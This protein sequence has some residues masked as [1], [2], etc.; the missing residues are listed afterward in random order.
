MLRKIAWTFVAL[1][2]AAT[3]VFALG[4]RTPVDTTITFDPATIGSDLDAYLAAEEAKVPGIRDGLQKEIIWAFPQSKAKT[5]YA[6]VYV[7]GFSASKGEVRPLPDMVASALG[8]NLF[9]TRLTGHGQGGEAMASAS[10]NA[11]VNDFAEAL[12]IGRTIGEKVILIS[13]STG[14]GLV[15]LGA[16]QP[17]LYDNVSH[18]VLISPNYGVQAGGSFLL[19]M[20]W[21]KQLAELVA[22]KERSW[23]PVNEAHAKY[24]TTR[25][26]TQA[27]LPMAELTKLASNTVVE[28]ATV[29]ALFIISDNDKVVRPDITRLM[30]ARWGGPHRLVVVEKTGDPSNHVIAGDALSPETTAIL[31]ERIIAW[32]KG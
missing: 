9:Y 26:P 28:K 2:L 4:P 6:V 23:E 5:P 21:A 10:V 8:A 20:P 16:V 7:H 24:W 12:A 18:V 11:W 3:V 17:H 32:I 25:Y 19:T 30:E 22:G 29:P 13:T 1:I 27:L 31:T 15:T 14:G